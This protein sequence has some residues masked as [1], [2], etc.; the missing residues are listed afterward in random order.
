MRE[1]V[2]SNQDPYEYDD[3]FAQPD[4]D[5]PPGND[6]E[7]FSEPV[8]DA[9][10]SAPLPAGPPPLPVPTGPHRA[11]QPSHPAGSLLATEVHCAV[12]G[13]NL[14]GVTIGSNCPECGSSVNLSLHA[15]SAAP[16]AGKAITALVLGICS[17]PM[18]CCVFIGPV[19]GV[20]GL[21]FGILALKEL[22]EG[23]A[24]RSARG[25]AI[26]GLVCSGVGIVISVGYVLLI[27]V[28]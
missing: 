24:A 12:C 20:L 2:L 14:T 22:P 21:I 9:G 23:P 15:A 13:Y 27:F 8:D 4:D 18:F 25:M 19:L 28:A 11:A 1:R 7:H 6:L 10:L 26:A 17:I 16:P 5:P 3:P